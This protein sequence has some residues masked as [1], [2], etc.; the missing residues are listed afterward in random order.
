MT[1]ASADKLYDVIVLG[2]GGMGSS[3][4]YSLVQRGVS[5]LGI[6]QFNMAHALGSSHGK[7]RLIRKAYAEHPDYVPL[8]QR[9]YELWDALSQST[10]DTLFHRTGLLYLGHDQSELCRGVETSASLH[11]IPIEI[12]TTDECT[13]RFPQFHVPDGYRA[14]FERDAGYIDVEGGVSAFCSEAQR[15]GAELH[16]DERVVGWTSS[17]GDGSST[18]PPIVTVTTAHGIYRASK[19]VLA[20]GAWSPS[21]L[22]TKNTALSVHKVPLFWFDS[23]QPAALEAANG[24]PCFGVHMPHAFVYGFPYVAGDGIKIAAHI[25]GAV[26]PDPTA[27]DRSTVT[28]AELAPVIDCINACLPLVQPTPPRAS[29]VCMYTMTPDEHFVLDV[30]AEYPRSVVVAAGF[31]GHGYKFA[32]VIGDILADLALQDGTT[33]HPIAF[34]RRRPAVEAHASS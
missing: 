20:A 4:C 22:Q 17:E 5:V 7:S 27:L 19:L 3:A 13:K 24:M 32:P 25:P 2:L 29:A 26:V 8:L 10:G 34:L 18:T 16:F 12:L 23:S 30:H 9:S 33:A 6:D 15:L 14:I 11:D 31:S 21:M 28:A 1:N